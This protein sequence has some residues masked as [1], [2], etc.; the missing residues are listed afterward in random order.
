[1]RPLTPPASLARLK[2]VSM[3]SFIWRPSSLAGP[4]NG[5]TMPN[6]I[7]LAVTPRAVEVGT[8]CGTG[9]VGDITI[10]QPRKVVTLGLVGRGFPD[11][12]LELV[13][14]ELNSGARDVGACQRRTDDRPDAAGEVAHDV[15]I[16]ADRRARDACEQATKQSRHP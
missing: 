10:E 8:G 16:V 15:G 13:A 3:P 4:E 1:M 11:H 14:D 6:R 5:A 12:L 7:S 2:A 9:A